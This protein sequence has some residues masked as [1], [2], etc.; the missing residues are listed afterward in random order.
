MTYEPDLLHIANS[1]VAGADA[2]RTLRLAMEELVKTCA[3]E[4]WDHIE[5][6]RQRA[7]DALDSFFDHYTTVMKEGEG[8]RLP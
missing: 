7:H 6:C 4:N 5:A 3:E 8:A 1:L 2:V